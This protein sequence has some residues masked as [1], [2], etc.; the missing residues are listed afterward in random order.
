MPIKSEKQYVLMAKW[1]IGDQI[2][3][4]TIAG[5]SIPVAAI[6]DE[7]ERVKALKALLQ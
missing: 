5:F 4:K 7:Q 1:R 2:T 6:F 3:A